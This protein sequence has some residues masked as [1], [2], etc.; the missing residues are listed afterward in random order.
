M[1][2]NDNLDGNGSRPASDKRR[3]LLRA[4][5]LALGLW[6]LAA[7]TRFW[8]APQLARLPADYASETRFL[9]DTRSRETPTGQWT[10]ARLIARR[11]DQTLV[12][13][14]DTAI[15]QG[16]LHWAT[17]SGEVLFESAGIYGVNRSTR[18]NLSGYGNV[19]RSGQ[20]LFPTDV[21]R[22]KYFYW[23]PLYIGPRTA[24]FERTDTVN[25]LPVYVFHFTARN[26]NETAGFSHLP[27]VPERYEAHT[28]GQGTMWIE[29][30]S[31]IV[32][33]YDESGVSY[34]FDVVTQKR[35]ADLFIW[36]D[37]FAP[38]TK[39]AQLE[40]ARAARRRSRTLELWLPAALLLGGAL[41][42]AMG[43]RRVGPTAPLA[44]AENLAATGTSS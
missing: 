15:V 28:D 29:P 19:N 18:M 3:R 34:F 6:L 37:H 8:I 38:E 26:L 4:F 10:N 33:D 41:C 42:L 25:G 39:A 36:K 23:D 32:V 7:L 14:G 20:F 17:E 13:S 24:T 16:D 5:P 30:N 27:D 21:Q 2:R 11:V 44:P 40:L 22:R 35:V 12:T 43:L 9:A 1:M 31:G